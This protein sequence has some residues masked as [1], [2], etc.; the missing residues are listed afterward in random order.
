M[1]NFWVKFVR[2]NVE[3]WCSTC[4]FILLVVS[5]LYNFVE[6]QVFPADLFVDSAAAAAEIVVDLREAAAAG[7]K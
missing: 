5:L 4:L 1:I 6:Q 2:S 7:T 3:C